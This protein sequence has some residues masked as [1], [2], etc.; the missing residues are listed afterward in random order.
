MHHTENEEFPQRATMYTYTLHAQAQAQSHRSRSSILFLC[1]A[2]FLPSYAVCLFGHSDS[3]THKDSLGFAFSSFR[4]SFLYFFVLFFLF[5]FASISFSLTPSHSPFELISRSFVRLFVCSLLVGLRVQ[6]NVW[7]VN[8]LTPGHFNKITSKNYKRHLYFVLCFVFPFS[9]LF[10]LHTMN[11]SVSVSV[12]EFVLF[13]SSFLL[14]IWITHCIQIVIVVYVTLALAKW[15]TKPHL[16]R[17]D[18]ERTHF[19]YPIPPVERRYRQRTNE[20]TKYR[21]FRYIMNRTCG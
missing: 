8:I 6:G 2:L 7:A 10:E 5:T 13:D 15:Q 9:N 16:I 19:C 3:I 1:P 11:A 18:I 21:H 14:V 12:F 17:I 20:R 4:C